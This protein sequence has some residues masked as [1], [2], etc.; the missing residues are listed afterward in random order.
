MSEKPKKLP[1]CKWCAEGRV[2]DAKGDHWIVQSGFPARM[3]IYACK[4]VNAGA[5][6]TPDS[7]HGG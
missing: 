1:R 5:T 6:P 2:P 4:R 7:S 3:S